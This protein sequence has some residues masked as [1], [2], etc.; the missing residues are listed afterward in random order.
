[1]VSVCVCL[2]V[3]RYIPLVYITIV[4]VLLVVHI[5][6]VYA[7]F[8]EF[9]VHRRNMEPPDGCAIEENFIFDALAS[10]PK[11][12]PNQC[13]HIVFHTT[14][15]LYSSH[16]TFPLRLRGAGE[17]VNNDTKFNEIPYLTNIRFKWNGLP[18]IDF[19]EKVLFILE[20]GLG[21]MLI[22]GGTLLQA[23]QQSDPGGVMGNPPRAAASQKIIDES[24]SRKAKAFHCMMNYISPHAWLYKYLNRLMSGQGPAAYD[25]ICAF[26]PIPVPAR[27]ATA[28]EDAWNR[29][30]M[31]PLRM[32]LDL[33]GLLFWA[34]IVVE[35]GR[36]LNK[37]CAAQK[38]KFLDGLPDSF[39]H[40]KQSMHDD[41]AHVFP[42]LYGQLP[43]HASSTLAAIPHPQAGQQNVQALARAHVSDWVMT[44]ADLGVIPR[45]YTARS[46]EEM[47]YLLT[48]DI[49]D[50][51]HI[52]AEDVTPQHECDTCG[53]KGHCS[54][55]RTKDG[56]IMVCPT[57]TL[58]TGKNSMS[59]DKARKYKSHAKQLTLELEDLT[60]QL[61]EAHKLHDSEARSGRRKQL[62][63]QGRKPSSVGS[64]SQHG[65]GSELE[66]DTQDESGLS[67]LD[68]DDDDNLS[69]DSAH[70]A[71]SGFAD[72]AIEKKRSP[73]RNLRRKP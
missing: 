73:R 65:M 30:G 70:S 47:A 16:K 67:A 68:M 10:Y 7:S 26:G 14:F 33:T 60:L 21:T 23:V 64:S 8:M 57:K 24:D 63:F 32:K 4:I 52:M 15:I 39:K 62:Q 44:S 11:I 36:I 50:Y 9:F 66:E 51:V 3:Y 71:I 13:L 45:G 34:E 49:E 22:N 40:S 18:C 6:S 35:Q 19:R 38:D 59:F 72:V 41:M 12:I 1:M 55:Q 53:G 48:R 25:I 69:D 42:A 58:G 43:G 61:E 27:I 46:V 28:R 17:D 29:M 5:R 2:G 31:L 56:E 37:T 54:T 20:N